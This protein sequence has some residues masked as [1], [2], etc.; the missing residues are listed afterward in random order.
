VAAACWTATALVVLHTG[1]YVRKKAD[2]I[3]VYGELIADEWTT[4]LQDVYIQCDRQWAYLVPDDGSDRMVLKCL[5]RQM[6]ACEN[7]SLSI[8]KTHV[9]QHL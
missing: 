4:F 2:T 9:L 8:Y 7:H 3:K 6:I 5:C 1:Q